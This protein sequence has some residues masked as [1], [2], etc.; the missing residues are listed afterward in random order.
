MALTPEEFAIKLNTAISVL[1]NKMPNIVDDI[2]M[3]QK[4]LMR[5]RVTQEGM[6]VDASGNEVAFPDYTKY[7]GRKKAEVSSTPNRL[8]LS[9]DMLRGL[10]IVKREF[11]N[12]KYT[13]TL[14]GSNPDSENRLRWNDERYKNILKP[15]IK[16]EQIMMDAFVFDISKVLIDALG[17]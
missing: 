17:K 8:V 4:Q 12:G 13:T 14:G 7:Y 10:T 2:A 15:S 1:N 3:N 9:G 5:T 6:N 16:E 11:V